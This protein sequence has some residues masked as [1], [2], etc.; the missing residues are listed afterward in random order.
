MQIRLNG[1][2][3][4][5]NETRDNCNQC[6]ENRSLNNPT[7]SITKQKSIEDIIEENK[8]SHVFVSTKSAVPTLIQTHGVPTP[9]KLT[10]QPPTS[11]DSIGL[12]GC[13]VHNYGAESSESNSLSP[14]DSLLLLSPN[15]IPSPSPNGS[16]ASPHGP[17]GH[18]PY[19]RCTNDPPAPIISLEKAKREFK[20][21]SKAA[22]RLQFICETYRRC[23]AGTVRDK[24]FE[25][26]EDVLNYVYDQLIRRRQRKRTDNLDLS[27]ERSPDLSGGR[28]PFLH[29]N[30]T[31][32]TIPTYAATQNG[33]PRT[34][35]AMNRR[36][37]V[38]ISNSHSASPQSGT[39]TDTDSALVAS[40]PPLNKISDPICE[41]CGTG[42]PKQHC[43]STCG[44][45]LCLKC[46]VN[47]F[48]FQP[49][50][51][52]W[53]VLSY[54]FV[55]EPL[56][57]W[58]NLGI[59]R[60]LNH[61][62][63][64]SHSIDRNS[65]SVA[66]SHSNSFSFSV[67]LV[68]TQRYMCP[69]NGCRAMLPP[70][71]HFVVL[72][73]KPQMS[74]TTP[75]PSDIE[76]YK[77]TALEYYAVRNTSYKNMLK[78]VG[79]YLS[80]KL[81]YYERWRKCENCDFGFLADPDVDWHQVFEL[82]CVVCNVVQRVQLLG[83]DPCHRL[84]LKKSYY[85]HDNLMKTLIF[86][87]HGEAENNVRP[88]DPNLRDPHLTDRG[89]EQCRHLQQFVGRILNVDCILCSS[90]NRTIETAAIGVYR[91]ERMGKVP[92]VVL[93][94]LRE[95]LAPGFNRRERISVKKVRFKTLEID[96]S[97]CKMD[98]D[99]YFD[100]E[101]KREKYE[102]M[103]KRAWQFYKYLVAREERTIAVV[104]HEGML[105]CL[106]NII[107]SNDKSLRRSFKNAE[108]RLCFLSH[109]K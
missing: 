64:S 13:N 32:P 67:S 109:K 107:E 69:V 99:V 46:L 82:K 101:W 17:S 2:A 28:S 48:T 36:K 45:P 96:W 41:M 16:T 80:S 104:S 7:F 108:A 85:P 91:K 6:N 106:M 52:R 9:R 21:V 90:M 78:I 47:T 86:I 25:K 105:Q 73:Y 18:S 8:T 83:P 77:K 74:T 29:Q 23:K 54:Y 31:N 63:S 102:N 81:K 53:Y 43:Y 34:G 92:F 55:N 93:E 35:N 38:I 19:S 60:R 89:R 10:P 59:S 88:S 103:N 1:H 4:T 27:R 39:P 95:R 12:I 15:N 58:C 11:D 40:R 30:G 22:V 20:T 98:D 42:F 56:F 87:R 71:A 76:K 14:N 97:E 5:D 57:L 33:T 26:F 51:P 94:S 84:T 70:Q 50:N 65:Y 44:H 24:D 75:N 79:E 66:I 100:V 72:S 49:K 61:L 3:M 62:N 37:G 68:V